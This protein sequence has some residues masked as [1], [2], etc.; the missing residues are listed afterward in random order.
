[1]SATVAVH[2]G[3]QGDHGWLVYMKQGPRHCLLL[4]TA[5][6]LSSEEALWM[7]LASWATFSPRLSTPRIFPGRLFYPD[8]A[9]HIFTECWNCFEDLASLPS[10]SSK[11]PICQAEMLRCSEGL[12][13]LR[14]SKWAPQ[15]TAEAS[16]KSARIAE[17]AAV[18]RLRPVSDG[19]NQWAMHRSRARTVGPPSLGSSAVGTESAPGL[20][21]TGTRA[22][23]GRPPDL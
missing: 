22:T 21:S 2:T 14:H 19:P 9:T 16:E 20:G 23:S 11:S 1:M 8:E 7:A 4:D 6:G 12:S 5:D 10:F 18:S 17:D 3:W 13:K 15:P